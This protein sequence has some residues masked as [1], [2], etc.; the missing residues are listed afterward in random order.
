MIGGADGVQEHDNRIKQGSL[1]QLRFGI[2]FRS[3]DCWSDKL[4][5]AVGDDGLEHLLP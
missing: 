3:H 5:A 4:V 1:L 2:R